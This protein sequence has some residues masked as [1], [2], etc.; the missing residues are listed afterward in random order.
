MC[1]PAP[2]S[3]PAM[4]V[5][6]ALLDIISSGVAEIEDGY[7]AASRA[8][9]TLNDPWTPSVVEDQVH[10][11][12]ERVAAAAFQLMILVRKPTVTLTEA[13]MSVSTC[14]PCKYGDLGLTSTDRCIPRSH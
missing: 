12:A 10:Q 2:L 5:L 6:R 14:L 8:P 9:P 3:F 11:T 7:S 13:S 1:T 4:T